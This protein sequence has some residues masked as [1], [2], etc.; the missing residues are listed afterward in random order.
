MSIWGRRQTKKKKKVD[1][2]KKQWKRI[3]GN[4]EVYI[5]YM[6]GMY[7]RRI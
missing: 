7:T 6:T 2:C 5:Y 4:K 3:K 1:G